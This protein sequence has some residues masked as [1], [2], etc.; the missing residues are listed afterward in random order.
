ML[1]FE[2][3]LKYLKNQ[4]WRWVP[5]VPCLLGMG[6][7]ALVGGVGYLGGLQALELVA[8]DR[9]IQ[10]RPDRGVDSRLLVVEI[11]E[12]DIRAMKRWPPND[13]VIAQALAQLQ[14]HEPAVIGLDVVRDVPN[15]PGYD[16]LVTQ[17]QQPNVISI[18]F[19]SLKAVDRIAPPPKAAPEQIG[20]S[21]VPLDPDGRVRRNL[22]FNADGEQVYPSFSL[23]LALQYLA[24]EGVAAQLTPEGDFQLGKTVLRRWRDT[25]GG[26]QTVD[27]QGYLILLDYRSSH[28]I[29][30]RIS[31]SQLLAGQ[32][33]PDWVRGKI[34]LLGPT[35]P[36]LK[37]GF[38]T[39]YSG[40]I[41]EPQEL[42]GV[43]LHSQMVS[44][45]LDAALEGRSPFWFWSEPIELGWLLLWATLGSGIGWAVRHP[46]LWAGST[47]LA[48][49][50]LAGAG[51]GLFLHQGWVPVVEP[52]LALALTSGA[53]LT[54]QLQRDRWRAAQQKKMV[55]QLLGQQTSPEI[56]AA[57]WNAR[58]EL[59]RSGMLPWQKLTATILFTDLKSFSALTEKASL[60]SLMVWLNRYL[61]A[62]TEEVQAHQG[63]VNKFTGDGLMAVFGVPVPH[64]TEA[65]IA[66]DA[67]NAVRCALAMRQRLQQFNQDFPQNAPLEMRVG[68]FT[69][70][71]IVGSLGGKS[72]LEYGVIGDSVNIAARLESYAKERHSV[73]CRI[74]IAHET[75][76]HLNQQ[77]AVEN[78]GLVELRGRD[79]PVQVYQV[80]GPVSPTPIHDKSP[81]F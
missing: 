13:Q 47:V 58:D 3:A 25:S 68:I 45:L 4:M 67:E 79:N 54:Y 65:E 61:N 30:R 76:V 38:F 59:L 20:F 28:S 44:Q 40:A 6:I 78:W 72:R 55:M 41:P 15:P 63:I 8:F 32:V 9:M 43:W 57:I 16:E 11:T 27:S 70:P 12:A 50:V 73:P 64:R 36:S 37:D 18:H 1:Q 42:P 35:A 23:Q 10:L 17:I 71:V 81:V 51:F 24:Y 34:V 60:E 26:Y 14:R 49:M 66:R 69:G 5:P 75:L 56:A 2:Q 22:M 19:L 46:L 21:N 39:P 29:A 31:L 62:M 33:D 48:G 80:V 77:F 53:V 74:L 52:G 7:T